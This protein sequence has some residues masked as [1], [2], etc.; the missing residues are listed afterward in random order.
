MVDFIARDRE[1]NEFDA[2]DPRSVRLATAIRD[3]ARFIGT[4]ESGGLLRTRSLS[5]IR[6]GSRNPTDLLNNSKKKRRSP[7]KVI[8]ARNLVDRERTGDV[9]FTVQETNTSDSDDGSQRVDNVLARLEKSRSQFSTNIVRAQTAYSFE[10]G[11]TNIDR[12][13][14]RNVTSALS[15]TG[16]G[17]VSG[18]SAGGGGGGGGGGSVSSVSATGGLPTPDNLQENMN[19]SYE[20]KNQGGGA[21]IQNA[22]M[23]AV[24]AGLKASF[25]GDSNEAQRMMD[26]LGSTINDAKNFYA[27]PNA[28]MNVVG[29]VGNM[30]GVSGFNVAFNNSMVQQFSGVMPRSFNFRWKLWAS[31]QSGSQAIFQLIDTL[32]Q[33]SHPEVVDPFL[34]IVRYPS[35]LSRFDVRGPNGLIIFPIFPCVITDITVDY[36]ASG[37]PFFFKSGAP[38]SIALSLSLTEIN[39]RTAGDFASNPSGYS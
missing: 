15:G 20:S 27:D 16:F 34:N 24:A 23:N 18:R 14:V 21:Q 38:V 19:L 22:V 25:G 39:S 26:N 3:G 13:V 31:S 1:I 11:G 9:I 17:G 32:K 10:T 37:A 29:A 8:D 2:Q 12:G 6:S 36:S 7:Q 5:E 4:T 33:A 28:L 30:A 35:V